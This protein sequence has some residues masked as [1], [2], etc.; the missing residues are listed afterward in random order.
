MSQEQIIKS[1]AGDVTISRMPGGISNENYRVTPINGDPERFLTLFPESEDFWKIKKDLKVSSIL[2]GVNV[3]IP[4]IFDHGYKIEDERVVGYLLKEFIDGKDFDAV[5]MDAENLSPK[6][7]E[8]LLGQLGIALSTMHNVPLGGFGL[9]K[10]DSISG[11]EARDIPHAMSWIDFIDTMM[12]DK[13]RLIEKIDGSRQYG[14]ITGADIK[15][16]FSEAK[17]FYLTNKHDLDN[18]PV[19]FLTHND[20]RMGNV[21][22]TQVGGV[23]SLGALI[24]HEWVLAGDPDIDLVQIEN[25]LQFAPYKDNFIKYKNTF[26]DAYKSNR[27]IPRNFDRKR[28]LYNMI[29]SISYLAVV[30]GLN[31]PIEFSSNPQNLANVGKH[32]SLL[33]SAINNNKP[34]NEIF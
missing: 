3:P 32:F 18:V 31:D 19:P 4:K 14:S 28:R 17:L 9:L 6:D 27:A 10:S 5:M 12:L 20:M 25:W 24:D 33:E 23:W 8:T 29:R 13:E 2:S 21:M 34:I 7:W 16:I 30:F 15:K 11:S 26:I 1:I 22:A